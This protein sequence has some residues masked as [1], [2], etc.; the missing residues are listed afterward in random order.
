MLRYCISYLLDWEDERL[1]ARF[2]VKQS[3][4]PSLYIELDRVWLE[5]VTTQLKI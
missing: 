2:H 5:L 4:L 1:G 3:C